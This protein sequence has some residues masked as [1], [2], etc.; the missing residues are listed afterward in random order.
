MTSRFFSQVMCTVVLT[1]LG[2]SAF[3]QIRTIPAV[4]ISPDELNWVVRDDG[5]GRA[6]LIGDDTQ[7]GMYVYRAKLPANF[8]NTPHSHPD[9]R[10]VTV[11]SG[12]LHVG[13]GVEF[14][15]SEMKVLP[16]G[17]IWTEPPNQAHFVWA[18]DGDVVI[19]IIGGN[20]PT[21]VIPAQ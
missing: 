10:I 8:K 14:E 3:A 9:E 6:D 18:K 12:T 20:G 11:I 21:G 15:E 16:A 13:Y 7:S 5:A 1:M 19:Q 2:S 17:S 4:R